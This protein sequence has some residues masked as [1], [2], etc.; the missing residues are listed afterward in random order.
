M[1]QPVCNGNPGP[2]H[3]TLEGLSDPS[4]QPLED[5]NRL[6]GNAMEPLAEASAEALS[7][8]WLPKE[9]QSIPFHF[10][11]TELTEA[12]LAATKLSLFVSLYM[13][14]PVALYQF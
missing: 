7:L 8:G 12:F 6:G 14:F 10:I 3:E 13:L 9:N 11:F 5:A 4:E 1:P 2:S